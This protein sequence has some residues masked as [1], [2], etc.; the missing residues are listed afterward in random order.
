MALTAVTQP[1]AYTI[2]LQK[3]WPTAAARRGDGIAGV[4]TLTLFVM[5]LIQPFAGA[6]DLDRIG[7]QTDDDLFGIGATCFTYPIFTTL[8]TVPASEQRAL[9]HRRTGLWSPATASIN[10]IIKAELFRPRPVGVALPFTIRV[11]CQK[12][13]EPVSAEGYDNDV[14]SYLPTTRPGSPTSTS[15][16]RPGW[17]AC[18]TARTAEP[19]RSVTLPAP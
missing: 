19:S 12:H 3:S 14:S 9:W 6:D 13:A 7:Q 11:H 2:Y 8:E 17:R 18:P 4:V 10:A 1:Y 16:A 15:R 5:L